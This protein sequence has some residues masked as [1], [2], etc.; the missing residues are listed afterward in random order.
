MALWTLLTD[1]GR[2]QG[3][4]GTPRARSSAGDG[5]YQ[6]CSVQVTLGQ[7]PAYPA[8]VSLAILRTEGGVPTREVVIQDRLPYVPIDPSE[9]DLVDMLGELLR[10]AR[11]TLAT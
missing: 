4:K 1:P 2:V 8:H 3:V 11:R 6:T 5:R 10:L 9:Q 7:D